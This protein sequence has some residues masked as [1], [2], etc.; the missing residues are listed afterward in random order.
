[1]L[2]RSAHNSVPIPHTHST[3]LGAPSLPRFLRIGWA[4][5]ILLIGFLIILFC[6]T[7]EARTRPSYGG[8]L[9]VEVEGD[10]LDPGGIARRMV[11][12]G[13]TQ[14]DSPGEIRP[15]LAVRWTSENNNHRWQFWLRSGVNFHN[16]KPL[17][18]L[19]VFTSLEDSCR[20]VTCP[21]TAIH[22]SAQS[23]VF[24]SDDPIPNLTS[25]LAEDAYLIRQQASP[26]DP[27][28]PSANPLFAGTGP[29][30]I[31][32]SNGNT[33]HLEANDDCWQ[34]RPFVDAIEILSH[35]AV[36]DQWTDFEAGKAD[37]VEVRPSDIRQAR[38]QRLNVTVSPVVSLLAL[39]IDNTSLAPQLRASIAAAVDRAALY[40]VLF[41]KQ[42]EV[43]ASLLPNAL[44]GYSFLFPT[45][46]DLAHAL[47]L[48]GGLTPPPLTLSF[49]GASGLQLAAERLAL[50]LRDAGFTVRVNSLQRADLA[51]KAWPL[52]G[53][54]PSAALQAMLR[55]FGPNPPVI[56]EDP[57]AA[58]K[59]E[60]EFL[61]QHTVIPLLYLPRA[62]AVSSRVRDLRIT[63]EGV[64]DFAD[65]SVP[66]PALS[67][68]VPS[69]EAAP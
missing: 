54:S 29:F 27:A 53:G 37:I 21:W 10:P 34:G 19:A 49:N 61:A 25:L 59:L 9:R 12:D 50:N 35:R 43:T 57:S 24:T 60:Q 30:H 51:L 66:A 13:L 17:N 15:A 6:N 22:I 39:Q 38:Q 7:A 33:V 1:V 48:R 26:D 44:T 46:R 32:D 42:G 18:A 23:V 45:D 55:N 11:F 67:A 69:S 28:T 14:V 20:K 52:N 63:V 58:Y 5:I 41:Q 2:R 36:R 68:P 40:Q 31:K 4:S 56:P 62:W 47:A 64:P 65:L 8:T 3:T 16:N